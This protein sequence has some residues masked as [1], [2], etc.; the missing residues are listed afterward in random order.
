MNLQP[1]NMPPQLH[2]LIPLAEKFGIADDRVREGLLSNCS[3]DE[4]HSLKEAIEEYNDEFDCCLAGPEAAGP[5]YT[6]EYI[7]FSALR[8]AADFQ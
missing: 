8:T 7:A 2:H 5:E 4:R 6:D 1:L 3:Q